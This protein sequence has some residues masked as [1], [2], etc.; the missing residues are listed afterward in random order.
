M[1]SAGCEDPAAA[2]CFY[3]D[4]DAAL[5][6][7]AIET[8]EVTL[9]WLLTVIFLVLYRILAYWV[10][11]WRGKGGGKRAAAKPKGEQP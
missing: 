3:V 5:G 4:G 8:D 9:S 6:A 11:I 7:F 2:G 1:C 10:L